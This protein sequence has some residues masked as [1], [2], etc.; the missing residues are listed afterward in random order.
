MKKLMVWATL[1]VVL[2]V[3]LAAPALAAGKAGKKV[4][5]AAERQ[6]LVSQAETLRQDFIV[7]AEKLKS[8]LSEA[9]EINN[10]MFQSKKIN[11]EFQQI[12]NQKICELFEMTNW[13]TEEIKGQDFNSASPRDL[14]LWIKKLQ[15]EVD[16][17][18]RSVTALENGKKFREKAFFSLAA[19]KR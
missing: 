9:A 18:K 19:E 2:L 14:R 4:I 1:A 3:L 8:A 13:E 5:S 15:V 7:S 6:N 10:K 16:G 17:L 12:Q 11:E